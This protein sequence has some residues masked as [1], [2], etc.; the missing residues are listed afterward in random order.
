MFTKLVVSASCEVTIS[1]V[2]IFDDAN[3]VKNENL[4]TE[5]EEGDEK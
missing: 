1:C 5:E 3:R 2:S 4:G